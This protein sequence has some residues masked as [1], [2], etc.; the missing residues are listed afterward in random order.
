MKDLI[1]TY[2]N[3]ILFLLPLGVIGV[4]RWSVWLIKKSISFFYRTPKGNFHSTLS[5][6]TPVYNEDPEMFRLALES[7]RLNQPD[8]IIAVIDYSNPELIEIFKHFTER[9]GGARLV[10]TQTPGKRAALADGV[11]ISSSEIVAMVDS[12]TIWGPKI[13]EKILA[14]FSDP[15]V[16][17]LTTR[18]DV[19]TTDTLARKLFKILL[20]DRYLTEYP[21]LATVSDAL[22]CLSGRTAVYRKVAI[23]DK[24]DDLVNETFWG[25][26]M[27]SGDDKTLTNF[28]HAAGWKSC[29]LRD[30]KVY[31]PGTPQLKNFLKQKLRWAR[32]GLR[33]DS[34]VL[35]SGWVWKRHK[36][37]ALLII[38]KFI[39]AIT[40][41][42]GPVYFVVSLYLG[43]WKVSVIILIWWL[44]SRAIKIF[45]HLKE[46]PFD[47][48]ILPVYVLMTF[49][50]AVVK[51]YAFFTLDKQGWITRWD[52]SRLRG[53][54]MLRQVS[55]FI[56]TAGFVGA[57][58]F[59]VGFFSEQ[60]LTEKPKIK[61]ETVAV[62]VISTEP[63]KISD[64]ELL[65]KKV[66]IQKA[67]KQNAYGF[68]AVR[69]GDTLLAISRKFNVKDI[70]LITYE[71]NVPI[72]NVNSIPIGKKIMIPTAS[73]QNPLVAN[74]LLQNQFRRNFPV[75]SYDQLSNTIFVKG[76][77]SVV[78]LP[79]IKQALSASEGGALEE[80]RLGEWILRANLYIGKNVTFV[81]DKR[82]ATYLKLKSD[83]GGFV[84]ILSQGGSML[85][86]ETK[87]TSWDES[88]ALPD[89]DFEKGRSYITAKSNGRMDVVNSEIA[90][91]GYE[92]LPKRGGPFGGSYGLSWKITSG[93]FKNELLTGSVVNS[94]IHD[95]YFGIYTFGA[96]GVVVSGNKVFENIQ[97]GIDPHDD[98]NN[99]LI[100]DNVVFENGN[101]GIIAS[102]RCFNNEI[103][104]NVSHGNKLH[105]IMLDRNSKNNIIEM[106]TVYGNI[107]GIAL[108]DSNDNLVLKNNIYANNQGIRLN[109]KSSFNYIENNQIIANGNGIHVYGEANKNIFLANN[110][111]NN[112]VG[113]SMR[114]A[115][116]NVFYASLK[117][118]ENKKDGNIITSEN[119]NEIK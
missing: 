90:Y 106:N 78:T 16:G 99:M 30:V 65:Q 87:V 104:G 68:Y 72:V 60:A 81:V 32:N 57:Y 63:R 112:D 46:K 6:V 85:F 110:V 19:L 40:I 96:T 67:I 119:E 91:L 3:T 20:D 86:S 53:L 94:S 97:Y 114:D 14:P 95:N 39:S 51:I 117:S 92:G 118:S 54:G 73:L 9:F 64:A 88:K 98:S 22:L 29:F 13:K 11:K 25:E 38:D 89:T 47:V 10:V 1:I 113:I 58:F 41:F 44:V 76:G 102:K 48:L 52:A 111:R 75:I 93:R 101:H 80:S 71:N 24:L 26:K 55:A 100:R 77:E 23:V 109:Q 7:W 35:L 43:Y 2:W 66:D 4:W 79:K 33:S 28:I 105:G 61:V 84:W 45:P 34:R 115:V 70:S 27:I 12:D 49:V 59:A 74:D 8:E 69:A 108:Y 18:Q 103:Y 42:L 116:G 36:I 83:E 21:F 17:G 107:D 82:D 50:M 62:D 37:L 5:I 31:T 15:N 56:L